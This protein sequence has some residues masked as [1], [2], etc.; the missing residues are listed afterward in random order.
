MPVE[1]TLG[2][3][4]RRTSRK[5]IESDLVYG[6]HASAGESSKSR[7]DIGHA[8]E[9]EEKRSRGRPNRR[10]QRRGCAALCPNGS[11]STGQGTRFVLAATE[12]LHRRIGALSSRIRLLEEALTN[13]QSSHPLLHPDLMREN[14]LL[15]CD[16]DRN[17]G[18][19]ERAV[20]I[21]GKGK[22]EGRGKGAE[23][24]GE[25]IDAF[26]T[27]SIS[28]H[29]ISRFFGPT[30]GV[31]SLLLSSLSRS[32]TPPFQRQH[33]N[34]SLTPPPTTSAF[35]SLSSPS[36][37][38]FSP[39]ST[40]S[41]TYTTNSDPLRLF[42][43]SFPFTP[44]GSPLD[45][46]AL[47]ASHL[48]PRPSADS[49]V[50]TY[51]SQCGWIFHGVTRAQIEEMMAKIYRRSEHDGSSEVV[52]DGWHER[53]DGGGEG[54]YSGPHDLAL[55]FV[56]FA[57]GALV[58]PNA[59]TNVTTNSNTK[60]ERRSKSRGH[61]ARSTPAASPP[62]AHGGAPVCYSPPS[63]ASSSSTGSFPHNSPSI[64]YLSTSPA[65]GQSPPQPSH[66]HSHSHPQPHSQP[67]TPTPGALADH[68][69]HLSTAALALQPV[70]EKPSLVT[71]QTLHLL[72]IY[73][74][75]S[76]SDLK[77]ETSMEVTWSLVTLAAHLSMAIGLHRDSA[78]W[79]LSPKMVQR[80]RILFWDLFVADVWQSL[81]TGRPPSF[82][83]AY[84]DCS[85]PDT[86]DHADREGSVEGFGDSSEVTAR[87]LT[88]EAPTYATIMELDK[89]VREF[90]LPEGMRPPSRSSQEGQDATDAEGGGDLANSF[91]RCVLD[92]IRETGTF[93]HSI[94]EHPE[95]PLKSAYAPSFLAAYRAASTILRSVREQ[96]N[97]YPISCARFWTMWTFAFSAAVVFGTVV[98]RGPR[99]P[100]APQAMV[101]LEQ[102]CLL[103]TKASSYSI[104]ATKALP[105]LTGL[106]DKARTALSTEPKDQNAGGLLWSLHVKQEPQEDDEL[107]IF[108]GH[109][110]FVST[111][112]GPTMAAVGS[113][114]HSRVQ[115]HQQHPYDQH[116]SHR[117]PAS[118]SIPM[119]SV[120]GWSGPTEYA[121]EDVT[122]H[123]HTQ[124]RSEMQYPY[125]TAERSTHRE[126]DM[127]AGMAV[128]A[129]G[130]PVP[131]TN[132]SDRWEGDWDRPTQGYIQQ[133]RPTRTMPSQV[134]QH[135]PAQPQFY[136]TPPL[137]SN[138]PQPHQY[139]S[140]PEHHPV[141]QQHQQHTYQS[142]MQVHLPSQNH[143]HAQEH[144][145]NCHSQQQQH[146]DYAPHQDPPTNTQLAGLGLASRDS[147]LDERWSSFMQDSG[148][149][150]DLNFPRKR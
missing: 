19:R 129:Y 2:K 4:K 32:P 138:I 20:G 117:A 110:R 83:L 33:S 30:G 36:T 91:Q 28:D 26:G 70:L 22:I 51:I 46:Q 115:T 61:S 65:S 108:A 41:H 31:E 121:M 128:E 142:H 141:M 104:R 43:S 95:N 73:N 80:R 130:S 76:G 1:P 89:R 150:E 143:R 113:E 18:S 114:V 71:I 40:T 21:P 90:P 127:D 37:S 82:S 66:S 48:P 134:V 109:T 81:N 39:Y 56:I 53:D 86:S 6:H 120:N 137:T 59:D 85:F 12:H 135:H 74:A 67:Q 7:Y 98:T 125:S 103:F 119:G 55:L 105:I 96:F 93:L 102:A 49:F 72:S 11:L 45:A 63:T 133:Q 126:I 145:Q 8:R 92:H 9:L 122:S 24:D 52:E 101:E 78:R 17:R 75:M 107:T 5:E 47:I 25:I 27:L 69:H 97:T 62:S 124:F 42:S 147:R 3:L 140:H 94:I 54:D 29:G 38:S 84:I 123:S 99:S 64:S 44:V 58:S 149:L 79:G 136:G 146:Q 34:Q 139:S 68:F 112:K 15:G 144:M 148:I 87:T 132:M 106:L 88:A 100:L 116:H 111:R 118:V 77:N 57:L 50:R 13:L 23:G 14:E 131:V 16:E 35:T 60:R 10:T